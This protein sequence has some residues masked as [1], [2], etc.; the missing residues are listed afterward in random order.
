MG[1]MQSLNLTL[2]GYRYDSAKFSEAEDRLGNGLV[3]TIKTPGMD[4]LFTYV[5]AF[6]NAPTSSEGNLLGSNIASSEYSTD[7]LYM[8]CG[9][10]D[11]IALENGYQTSVDE[12][13]ENAG[14]KLVNYYQVL[15]NGAGHDFKVW[16][17]G[18]YNYLRL[19]F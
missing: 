14:D 13:A 17:N 19:I 18:A 3:K 16:N 10:E 1:G 7:L 4:D 11:L 15:I 12:L 9:D 8:T 5:G 6:S 2:G